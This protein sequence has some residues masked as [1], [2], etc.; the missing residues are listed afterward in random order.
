M[1]AVN[2]DSLLEHDD[3]FVKWDLALFS[4]GF[5]TRDDFRNQTKDMGPE[6]LKLRRQLNKRGK[7]ETMNNVRKALKRRGLMNNHNLLTNAL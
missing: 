3:A 1:N 2:W 5:T 6:G 7:H 4:L